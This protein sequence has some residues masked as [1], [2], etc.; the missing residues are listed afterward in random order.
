MPVLDYFF[1]P[2]KVR[3]REG[4]REER[5]EGEREGG[6]RERREGEERGRGREGR[7]IGGREGGRGGDEVAGVS[8]Q[9]HHLHR[10]ML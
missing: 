4:G 5:G 9:H 2:R 3:G 7:G 1:R 8:K 10:T 6:R